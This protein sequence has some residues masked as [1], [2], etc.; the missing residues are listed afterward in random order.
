MSFQGKVILIT[1]AS[2]GIGAACAEYFAKEGAALA[3]VGRNVERCAKIDEKLRKSGTKPLIIVADISVDS[4]RIVDETIE[5]YGRLDILINCA[6]FSIPGTVENTRIEDFDAVMST[7]VR[8][9]FLLTQYAVPHLIETKGNI[10][11]VSSVVGLR[12]F[13]GVLAYCMSK[14]ALD[15]FTRCTAIELAGKG[16][17]VNSVNPAVTDTHF[18]EVEFGLNRNSTEFTELR[19]F[20]AKMH[21]IGRIGQSEEIVSAIAFLA[22]ENAG[23][24]T[25]VTLPI[26]GGL[27]VKAPMSVPT[28]Q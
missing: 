13:A 24:V 12:A 8:G 7:N 6:A 2:S 27:T 15:Q 14:A 26:D 23:F 20:H 18:H 17:R 10:V 16:V 4:K 1:G 11:N 22:N 25:G 5:M 21:P 28:Y 3:L 19:E 9:T